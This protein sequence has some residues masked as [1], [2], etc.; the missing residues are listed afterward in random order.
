MVNRFSAGT[1]ITLLI[2]DA[3]SYGGHSFSKFA[4]FSEKLTYLNPRG[5]ECQFFGKIGVLKNEWSLLKGF[6]FSVKVTVEKII[7]D[8]I[9][10]I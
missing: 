5:K 3:A 1:I 2:A 6:M 8:Y 7:K 4:K 10:V 9:T